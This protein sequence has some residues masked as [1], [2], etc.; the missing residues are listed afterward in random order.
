MNESREGEV[1][2]FVG[3]TTD[4]SQ[5]AWGTEASEGGFSLTKDNY[6]GLKGR[7]SFYTT[8]LSSSI[9]FF[10]FVF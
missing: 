3:R 9:F 8:S 7:T 10:S 5:M 2:I 6:K 1:I 4:M